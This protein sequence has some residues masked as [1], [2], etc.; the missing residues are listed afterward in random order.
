MGCYY[1][2]K[3]PRACVGWFVL[4]YSHTLPTHTRVQRLL[5]RCFVQDTRIVVVCVEVHIAPVLVFG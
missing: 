4:I 1:R 3:I 2:D 5:I